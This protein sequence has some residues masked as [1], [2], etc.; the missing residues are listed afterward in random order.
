MPR[1]SKRVSAMRMTPWPSAPI[2]RTTRVGVQLSPACTKQAK[3]SPQSAGG[4]SWVRAAVGPAATARLS[5][6]SPPR[7]VAVIDRGKLIALLDTAGRA[8]GLAERRDDVA[9]VEGDRLLLVAAHEV[10]V[11]LGDTE[12]L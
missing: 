4:G 6:R 11:E 12:G 3:S 1:S 7:A 10:D 9:A 5:V 8:D 2:V